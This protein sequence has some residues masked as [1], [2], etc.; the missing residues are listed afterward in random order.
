VDKNGQGAEAKASCES[1]KSGNAHLDAHDS[2]KLCHELAEIAERWW[3]LSAE[4]RQ[5]ILT[6]LR[7]AKEV[8]NEQ[9]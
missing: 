2:A 7:A 9:R 4:V 5:A 6:L 1:A 8:G 3:S